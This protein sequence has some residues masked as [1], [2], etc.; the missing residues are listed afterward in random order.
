MQKQ[1]PMIVKFEVKKDKIEFVKSELLKLIEP[2]RAE[3]GCVQY[4]LHQDIDDP[5]IFMFYEIWATKALWLEH[6]SKKHV[7]DFKK[8]LEG[9]VN[10]IT[11]NKLTLI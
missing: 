7:V 6:D 8:A 5:S 9:S 2:T 1:F 11:H 4:D 10:K 3:E